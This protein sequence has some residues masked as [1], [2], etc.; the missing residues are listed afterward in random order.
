MRQYQMIITSPPYLGAQKYIRASSLNLGWLGYLDGTR[1][2][3]YEKKTIGRE[4]LTAP[5]Y[6]SLKLTG[7]PVADELLAEAWRKN[8]ERGAI[9]ATYLAELGVSMKSVAAMLKPGGTMVVVLGANRLCGRA[10]PTPDI[11]NRMIIDSG[12][13][14]TLQLVDSI[15]SRGLMTKRNTTAGQI[16]CEEIR[17]YKKPSGKEWTGAS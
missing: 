4:H 17:V 2:R 12:L 1:L 14:L 16:A 9:A 10:F 5:E 8:E 11:V 13:E 7:D 3:E 6:S 15:R